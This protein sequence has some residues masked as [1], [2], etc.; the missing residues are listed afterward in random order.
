MDSRQIRCSYSFDGLVQRLSYFSPPKERRK[1]AV[2]LREYGE[3]AVGPLCKAL[4]DR[5]NDVRR[6]AA[7]S[8]GYIGDAR[9]V[10]PLLD[11]LRA[12]DDNV[13]K[14]ATEAL[15]QIGTPAVEPL[16]EMLR[17]SWR[18]AREAAAKAL[19]KIGDVRA[20]P[21]LLDA[22]N[23]DRQAALRAA[24]ARALG[25]LKDARAVRPLIARLKDK[26]AQVRESV[27][28]ALG[29]I[30]DPQTVSDAIE[31]LCAALSDKS[32]HVRLAAAE[33]LGRILKE[34][35][36]ASAIEPLLKGLRVCFVKGSARWHLVMGL[37]TTMALLLLLAGLIG[38]SVALKTVG[39]IQIL[40]NLFGWIRVYYEHRRTQSKTCQQLLEALANV[41]E[42]HPA[43]ELRVLLPDLKAISAD[44]IQQDSQTRA[45]SRQAAQKIATLTEQLKN[46]PLPASAPAPEAATLPRVADA[47]TIDVN[48]LPR[49]E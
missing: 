14:A 30:Q 10:Q 41:V 9:A 32:G 3:P 13:R 21:P 23:D 37:I 42:R 26:D 40:I 35:G 34:H 48:T 17:S 7:E 12:I 31:P 11:A 46:L 44:V 29:K 18:M 39:M 33:A 22:L 19:G 38:G 24:A 43:P 8:L 16:C 47:T 15:G 27:A 28:E 1:A 36:D 45:I 5:D 4:K 49:V 6:A 25:E 20:L 2:F